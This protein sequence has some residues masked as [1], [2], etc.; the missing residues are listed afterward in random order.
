LKKSLPYIILGLVAMGILLLVATGNYKKTRQFDSRITLR[1]SDKIPYG[2]Y[3]AYKNL[4]NIFP[5][6]SVY[7]DRHEPGYWDSLSN[8][9]S[10]QAVIILTGRFAADEFEMK[11][12]IKFAEKGNDVFIIAMEISATAERMLGC[13]AR[14]Y[15]LSSFFEPAGNTGEDTLTLQLKDFNNRQTTNYKYP[16]RSFNGYFNE[17]D[18]ITTHVLGTD[19]IGRPNFIQL[20]AG[21]GNFYVNMAPVAFSNYFLL[22][23][24][25]IGY[26]ERALSYIRPDVQKVV[27]DEYYLNKRV[28]GQDNEKKKGWFSVLMNLKNEEGKKPFRAA[29]WLAILLLLLYVLMEMRRKQRYIPVVTR[30]R[31]DSMDFVKTIGRLYFDKGDH[32]NLCY[33][34]SSYFLEYVRNKY[35]LP[36][37]KLDEEFITH[38]RYKSGADEPV[39]RSIVSFIKYIDDAQAISQPE[40]NEF[41]ELLEMFYKTA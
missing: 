1:K 41:H 35:K 2:A 3:V 5:A 32:R 37:S 26:Y 20:Q 17:V 19:A 22:H 8:Y 27:W 39:V 30:P 12:L 28:D 13:D 15:Y 6:A 7:T 36:T 24:K 25:N 11:Q 23:S 34:M 4:K 14:N 18:T 38:L 31:N 9:D 29:F 21:D 10:K 16:G 40:V 33:K